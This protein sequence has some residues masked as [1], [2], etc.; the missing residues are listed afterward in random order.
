MNKNKNKK[1]FYN[2]IWFWVIVSILLSGLF[3]SCNNH[4]N[5]SNN[6]NSQKEEV[7]NINDINDNISSIK[8]ENKNND[9]INSNSSKDTNKKVYYLNEEY[10]DE[11]C[12]LIMTDYEDNYIL[13]NELV[14]P[15]E[16]Y[17]IIRVYFIFT[18]ISSSDDYFGCSLI[19]CYS[20]NKVCDKYYYGNSNEDLSMAETVG[21]NRYTEGW[22]YFEV[23]INS[24]NIEFEYDY[25][26][27]KD[28]I[29]FNPNQK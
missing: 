25:S 26:L 27:I 7:L 28:N 23:P 24:T 1:P 18:N 5:K 11:K 8:E 4:P 20:D 14:P 3:S 13:Y 15:K 29:I 16:G 22:S 6:S 9:S 21:S 10:K 2:T 19:N 17:K 12:S